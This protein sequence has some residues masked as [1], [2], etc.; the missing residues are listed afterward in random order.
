MLRLGRGWICADDI[1]ASA[2]KH[3]RIEKYHKNAA[4]F[5]Q[6]GKICNQELEIFKKISIGSFSVYGNGCGA[7][8]LYNLTL[9]TRGKADLAQI[10]LELEYNHALRLNGLFGVSPHGIEGYLKAHKFDIEIHSGTKACRKS[11]EQ[12][13]AAILFVRNR[14]SLGEHYYCV[15]NTADGLFSMNRFCNQSGAVRLNP[16][17]LHGVKKAYCT[18]TPIVSRFNNHTVTR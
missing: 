18:K 6:G 7:L 15:I 8:A 17:E 14:H 9:M 5:D 12:Y 2:S 13:T 10:I 1:L 16:A 3:R 11:I 4:L